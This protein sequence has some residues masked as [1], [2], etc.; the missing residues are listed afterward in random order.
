MRGRIEL[1]ALPGET[2]F[3][4]LADGRYVGTVERRGRYWCPSEGPSDAFEEAHDAAE[5]L[6]EA[7]RREA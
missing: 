5:A 1:V 7:V 3:E 4:V 2:R 6:V